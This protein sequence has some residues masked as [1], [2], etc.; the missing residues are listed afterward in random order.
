MKF[1]TLSN[2][3]QGLHVTAVIIFHKNFKHKTDVVLMT[4]HV[5]ILEEKTAKMITDNDK[6]FCNRNPHN[7]TVS[8]M[9]LALF[10]NTGN[11]VFYIRTTMWLHV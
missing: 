9:L 8:E 11:D 7:K 10:R 3:D 1:V 5:Y 4:T 6:M 2:T